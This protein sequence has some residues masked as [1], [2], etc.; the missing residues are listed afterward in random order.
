M[1]SRLLVLISISLLTS[2]CSAR[3]VAANDSV[4][5]AK[6]D[7]K[8]TATCL[9]EGGVWIS[10]PNC[11]PLNTDGKSVSFKG[12]TC[13]SIAMC[14]S[15]SNNNSKTATC[16]LEGGVWIDAP[17]CL[18]LSSDGK[19]ITFKGQTCSTFAIC[20]P[21]SNGGTNSDSSAKTASCLLEGG[22][23]ITAPS[24]IPLNSDG[25]S[26]TFEGQTCSTIAMCGTDSSNTTSKTASCLLEGGVWIAAPSC[27]PLNSD[28]KSVSF[29]GQT[30]STISM[31][32]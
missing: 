8:K 13:S 11:L 9:L 3:K 26:V 32:P 10:A 20:E 27:L 24:C 19:S 18:P 14:G 22:V 23:W 7:K 12:Q 4:T 17:S 6:R 15:E 28:G 1:I 2:H 5:L 30:C 31:C 29:E 21:V 25:K 16:L